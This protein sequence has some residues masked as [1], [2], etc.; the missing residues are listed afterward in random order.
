MG[1]RYRFCTSD[2]DLTRGSSRKRHLGSLKE[3]RSM[4]GSSNLPCTGLGKLRLRGRKYHSCMESDKLKPLGNNTRPYMGGNQLI[5]RLRSLN[6]RY[7]L[8][9]RR[10]LTCTSKGSNILKD[11]GSSCSLRYLLH[12]RSSQLGNQGNPRALSSLF[13]CCRLRLGI[14]SEIYLLGNSTPWGKRSSR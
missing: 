14:E 6:Y 9:T 4:M 5:S 13:G 3:P 7:Q 12:C 10:A 2:T 8:G 11:R 1:S